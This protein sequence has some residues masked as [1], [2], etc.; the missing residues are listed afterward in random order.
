MPASTQK[1]IDDGLPMSEN[2]LTLKTPVSDFGVQDV[3]RA[4]AQTAQQTQ[5]AGLARAALEGAGKILNM[6][7]DAKLTAAAE[8]AMDTKA[9]K[10]M[11]DALVSAA[12]PKLVGRVPTDGTSPEIAERLGKAYKQQYAEVF[13]NTPI[14]RSIEKSAAADAKDLRH[15]AKELTGDAKLS[16]AL[17]KAADI[18]EAA[19]S[20]NAESFNTFY[21]LIN[22]SRRAMPPEFSDGRKWLDEYRNRIVKAMPEDKRKIL[23]DVDASYPEY[24]A[25]KD[26]SDKAAAKGTGVF[27]F[28]DISGS[29]KRYTNG[30][31]QVYGDALEAYANYSGAQAGMTLKDLNTLVDEGSAF[32][33]PLLKK[34]FKDQ[35]DKFKKELLG[36]R[37]GLGKVTEQSTPIGV[38]I[39]LGAPTTI[40]DF[41]E[42]KKRRGEISSVR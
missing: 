18:I 37:K 19:A 42:R 22:K 26:A 14:P 10:G 7:P 17:T 27:T 20:G 12:T 21:K 4:G 35:E 31:R 39:G 6:K 1:N 8:G 28:N 15:L 9:L 16:G 33:S 38:G 24:L 29:A 30:G 3:G 5:G 40:D 34:A 25:F 2:T 41:E 23:Q 32:N 11:N 13:D 36:H